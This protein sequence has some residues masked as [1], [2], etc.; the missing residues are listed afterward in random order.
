MKRF[1][2]MTLIISMFA[3]AGCTTTTDDGNTTPDSEN[4]SQENTNQNDQNTENENKNEEND[5]P[6]QPTLTGSTLDSITIK[7]PP[8]KTEY[9][10]GE[11]FDP[12]GLALTANY[13]DT[14]SDQ[15]TKPSAKDLA[16]VD[17][18]NDLTFT[19][20]DFA[21]AGTK[22]VT[23]TYKGK[24]ATFDVTVKEPPAPL[25]S[26]T[27]TDID[28]YKEQIPENF[29]PTGNILLDL[30]GEVS[31]LKVSNM[32]SD[33]P[34]ANILDNEKIVYTLS[35]EN[36]VS[37]TVSEDGNSAMPN[38]AYIRDM[39]NSIADISSSDSDNI[40]NVKTIV[41]KG[42]NFN[43]SGNIN[44]YATKIVNSGNASIE[45]DGVTFVNQTIY[46]F[47]DKSDAA[48]H[49][50]ITISDLIDTFN[51]LLPSGQTMSP[52][53]ESHPKVLY[54]A[55]SSLPQLALKL[56][57]E[58]VS[59][60]SKLK[61]QYINILKEYYDNG[62]ELKDIKVFQESVTADGRE[63]KAV[64]DIVGLYNDKNQFND[65]DNP[66]CTT[67]TTLPVYDVGFLKFA[68]I[69]G[70]DGF[71]NIVVTGDVASGTT[72]DLD[73]TNVVFTGDVS[74]I[75][76]TG[77]YEGVI[78]FKDEPMKEL[79]IDNSYMALIK[80]DKIPTKDKAL[81]TGG[82]MDFRDLTVD[83]SS[84][85]GTYLKIG[86]YNNG[87][88]YFKTEAQKNII[89]PQIKTLYDGFRGGTYTEDVPEQ[90]QYM[91]TLREIEDAANGKGEYTLTELL[92]VKHDTVTRTE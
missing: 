66:E 35:E 68:N 81:I 86:V 77:T 89:E 20:T 5:T 16:Y 30:T 54:T 47:V 73:F 83:E 46:H 65:P 62:E 88:G 38:E 13:T 78:H 15:S 43:L 11:T 75:D 42:K 92:R 84:D 70:V 32:A 34:S 72:T 25:T 37:V 69:Q 22:T 79:Q 55:F 2:I 10:A 31:L 1:F 58:N 7:T 28:K 80:I 51:N 64:D 90:E 8:A 44:L 82:I 12:A 39:S 53:L 76:N 6:A 33:Y 52:V 41:L 29:S 60:D 56:N 9:T 71:K 48:K 27:I 57:M 87:R 18:Q 24:N 19:G 14:Y 45:M 91:K 85:I 40:E 3:L 67:P 50:E 74:G 59:D 17:I 63:G 49:E 21:A 4:T 36:L 61:N 23:V 26:V